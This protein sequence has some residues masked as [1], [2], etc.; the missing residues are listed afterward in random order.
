MN[1]KNLVFL[2]AECGLRNFYMAYYVNIGKWSEKYD[3]YIVHHS[4]IFKK[5]YD[6]LLNDA[7]EIDSGIVYSEFL[8][9][10]KSKTS[11]KEALSY[12]KELEQKYNLNFSRA[13]FAE[14][15]RMAFSDYED[16]VFRVFSAWKFF[17]MLQELYKNPIFV[18]FVPEHIDD[19]V[20]VY[21]CKVNKLKYYSF[22]RYWNNEHVRIM[23]N[24]M[25]GVPYLMRKNINILTEEEKKDNLA[26]FKDISENAKKPLNVSSHKKK[27]LFYN[28][29]L[30]FKNIVLYAQNLFLN[31]KEEDFLDIIRNPSFY[32]KRNIYRHLQPFFYKI[33]IRMEKQPDLNKDYYFFPLHYEPELS[34]FVWSYFVNNQLAVIENIAKSIPLHSRL[35]VK[36]HPLW[37]GYRSYKDYQKIKNIPN[38]VL[39][40]DMF[41]SHKLIDNAKGIISINGTVILES[42]FKKRPILMLGNEFSKMISEN[43]TCNS[44]QVLENRIINNDFYIAS[45]K[46]LELF[47]NKFIN[48]FTKGEIVKIPGKQKE[49]VLSDAYLQYAK[50]TIDSLLLVEE[51]DI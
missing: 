33:F 8:K 36:D 19:I 25:E 17:E 10:L 14:R 3:A 13:I 18:G 44:F 49:K 38:V 43:I 37:N 40:D 9:K 22:M 24:E 4:N 41:D 48:S 12:I 21:F 42:I 31:F 23:K 28:N 6:F 46:D 16:F 29:I 47:K 20:L 7:K 39:V 32:I 51:N 45:E 30:L 1:K 26:F 50:S 2:R 35:Y 34:L 5:D 27:S 11:Y 15:H